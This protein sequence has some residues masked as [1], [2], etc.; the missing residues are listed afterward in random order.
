M[1]NFADINRWSR[2][3]G[4]ASVKDRSSSFTMCCVT[5]KA[6]IILT[7]EF[8]GGSTAVTFVS[9]S[10]RKAGLSSYDWGYDADIF[11]PSN[12][13]K[14][15]CELGITIAWMTSITARCDLALCSWSASANLVLNSSMRP[16]SQEV[17]FDIFQATIMAMLIPKLLGIYLLKGTKVQK[18]S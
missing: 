9:M 18:G 3:N 8:A 4:K 11:K 10:E 6:P 5:T 2:G 1:Q 16:W 17:V 14:T 15:C 12:S 7:F 13:K